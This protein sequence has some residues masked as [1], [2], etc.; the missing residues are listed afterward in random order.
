M[1][2][3]L[4]ELTLIVLVIVAIAAVFIIDAV[5][6][7]M[8]SFGTEKAVFLTPIA[9]R[10]DSTPQYVMPL[11]DNYVKISIVE[12]SKAKTVMTQV[13][14]IVCTDSV[15]PQIRGTTLYLPKSSYPYARYCI[16]AEQADQGLAVI[17]R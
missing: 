12:G 2:E 1:R 7:D 4:A 14:R 6:I 15:Q 5:F 9:C 11:K 16:A 3:R 10:A 13:H 8:R 17:L